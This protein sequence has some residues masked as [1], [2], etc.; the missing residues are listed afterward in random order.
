M[1]F[2]H[3]H[4]NYG[5]LFSELSD[6]FKYHFEFNYHVRMNECATSFLWQLTDLILKLSLMSNLFL[7]ISNRI[8]G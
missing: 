2:Y 7:H 1:L 4:E 5:W 3:F 6:I 8:L